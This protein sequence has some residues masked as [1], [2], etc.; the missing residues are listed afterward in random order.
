M[1]NTIAND[2]NNEEPQFG[3]VLEEQ[4][5]FDFSAI[6]ETVDATILS[7]DNGFE[8]KSEEL[9]HNTTES[10]AQE[11]DSNSGTKPTDRPFSSSTIPE[12]LNEKST[13]LPVSGSTL[14]LE[15]IEEEVSAFI[16]VATTIILEL[17][18]TSSAMHQGQQDAFLEITAGFLSFYLFKGTFM[19]SLVEREGIEVELIRQTRSSIGQ[20]IQPGEY[21]QP[22]NDD[23]KKPLYVVFRVSG[24]VDEEDFAG[25]NLELYEALRKLFAKKEGEFIESLKFIDGD[26]FSSL[27]KA[28]ILDQGTNRDKSIQSS[29]EK[30]QKLLYDEEIESFDSM[31]ETKNKIEGSVLSLGAIIGISI[32]AVVLLVMLIIM[33]CHVYFKSNAQ[34]VRNQKINNGRNSKDS[35]GKMSSPRKKKL[36]NQRN[37]LEGPI[38]SIANENL[39]GSDQVQ[40]DRKNDLTS[41]DDLES[42]AMYSYNQSQWSSGS[43]YTDGSNIKIHSNYSYNYGSDSMSYTYSLE[44]GIEASVVE[45]VVAND[46]SGFSSED[47][48][49]GV[50]PIR[51]IPQVRMATNEKLGSG[52]HRGIAT[53][54]RKEQYAMYDH[55]GNTQIEREPSELKLTKSELEML[56]SNLRGSSEESDNKLVTRKILAPQGKL[57]IVI[58]TSIEGP[59]VHR[60]NKG[61]QLSEQIFPGDIIVAIDEVDTRAMS[62]SSITAVMVKTANKTRNLTVKR[63]L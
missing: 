55:F 34:N 53:E 26:F 35:G 59:V 52:D 29:D 15:N 57:G 5:G 4:I 44:P 63:K 14:P 40:S 42:Q 39:L 32:S 2:R 54:N 60:V 43:V 33:V 49:I 23:I 9:P 28:M 21:V 48:G 24:K 37:G 7:D 12:E 3:R 8:M 1:L 11:Y 46:R 61:S 45:G 17:V 58:D 22:R 20:L 25:G 13:G 10:T 30:D 50:V 6:L 38:D 47:N 16:A 62:S 19:T 27:N 41:N 36:W 51:E 56:P 18:D 31:Q